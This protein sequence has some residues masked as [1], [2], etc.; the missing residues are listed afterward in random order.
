[1]KIMVWMTI[2]KELTSPE[3][4]CQLCLKAEPSLTRLAFDGDTGKANHEP[5][6]RKSV[7]MSCWAQMW[8]P[9]G[10]EYY[11]AGDHPAPPTLLSRVLQFPTRS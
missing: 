5:L 8:L 3:G 7:A 2:T 4:E 10:E 6:P 11:G 9:S 1:M